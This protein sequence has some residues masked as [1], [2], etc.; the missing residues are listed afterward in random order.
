MIWLVWSP[1]TGSILQ[2]LI[3]AQEV[4]ESSPPTPPPPPPKTTVIT[5]YWKVIRFFFPFYD[6][7]NMVP[8]SAL[9]GIKLELKV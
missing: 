5:I 1:I 4:Q 3:R 8:T 6:S 9:S 2:R 7:T